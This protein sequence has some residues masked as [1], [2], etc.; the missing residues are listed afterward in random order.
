MYMMYMMPRLMENAEG[1]GLCFYPR[2]MAGPEHFTPQEVPGLGSR[3]FM[4][5]YHR[6]AALCEETGKINSLLVT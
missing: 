1:R 5:H 4:M 6:Q 2:C 3:S